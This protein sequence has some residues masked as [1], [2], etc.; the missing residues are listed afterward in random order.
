MMPGWDGF[1]V[2][3]H[4]Q[5]ALPVPVLVDN[6]VNIM[7]LGERTALARAKISCSSRWPPASARASSAAVSAGAGPTE[8][9]ATSDTSGSRAAMTCSAGAEL[10]V[11][12]ARGLRARRG[13]GADAA[14]SAGRDG[15]DV[16]RLVAEGNLQAIQ[17]LRQAGRDSATSSPPL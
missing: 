8:P 15:G 10:R 3:R 14:R 2:V 4:V 5:R 11:P 7:A 12:G 16:L 13:Q 9:P 6:D 1:D 17:A